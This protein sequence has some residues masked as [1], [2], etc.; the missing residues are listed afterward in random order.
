MNFKEFSDQL[1]QKEQE[2]KG[3]YFKINPFHIKKILEIG[4]GWGITARFLLE[5]AKDSFI[6]T[7][8]SRKELV[9]FDKNVKG[10]EGRYR[11]HIGKSSTVLKSLIEQGK[12]YELI[13]VDGSHNYEDVKSD[14]ELAWKL[15]DD[16]YGVIFID[17]YM[18]EHNFD[19]DYGV[20]RATNEFLKAKRLEIKKV[21]I[22]SEANGLIVIRK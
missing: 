16:N 21:E 18:H 22:Y 3:L 12:K 17:D 1:N 4:S 19:G 20:T 6:D 14:L 15:L 11:R 2:L 10:F 9:D 8:D 7:I 13:L 5:F